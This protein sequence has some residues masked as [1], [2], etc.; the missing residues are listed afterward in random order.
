MIC[1][2]EYLLPENV[3]SPLVEDLH[4]GVHFF[5]TSRVLTDNIEQ[6]LTMIGHKV[7]VL[8]ENYAHNIVRSICLDLK[9]ML[10][11]Q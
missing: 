11:V 6:C 4:N 9:G 3:M 1:V 7:A 5:V 10:Q 8:R 2:D